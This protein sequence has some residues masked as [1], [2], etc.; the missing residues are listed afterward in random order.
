MALQPRRT[1]SS[2]QNLLLISSFKE[3][4]I[5]YIRYKALNCRLTVN[6]EQ[7][8]MRKKE[9]NVINQDLLGGAG[10][11]ENSRPGQLASGIRI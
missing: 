8:N 1:S 11:H 9:V 3:R 5:Y 2:Y 6:F 7:E 10:K 4:C